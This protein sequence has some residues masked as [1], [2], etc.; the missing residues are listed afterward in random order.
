MVRL[1]FLIACIVYLWIQS[2]F[3]QTTHVVVGDKHVF[4]YGWV[5]I[6]LGVGFNV[7]PM[8]AAWF[9]WRVQKDKVG[10]G[11]FLL[12]IPLIGFFVMPQ[13]LM[14]RVEVT[15][16]QLIHRR[17]PPH[18]KYNADVAFDEILS[19]TELIQDSGRKG[20]LLKLKDNRVLELPANTVLTAAR[21]TIAAELGR[22]NIPVA[23]RAVSR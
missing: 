16:T 3:V 21:D 20:Y 14:E 1:A 8:G 10:A 23:T 13:L 12:C 2:L 9:L 18:T 4:A 15:P 5:G 22:R 6:G 11:I 19:A 7:I 17:E